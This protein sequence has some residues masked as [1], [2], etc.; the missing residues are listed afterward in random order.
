MKKAHE[1]TLGEFI[2]EISEFPT[3]GRWMPMGEHIHKIRREEGGGRAENFCSI[4]SLFKWA[5]KQHAKCIK[6]AGQ[7]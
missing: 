4:N 5:K 2:G 7:R 3:G 6:E 1:M